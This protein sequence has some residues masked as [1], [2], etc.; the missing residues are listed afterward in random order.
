MK[1]LYFALLAVTLSACTSHL[2][3]AKTSFPDQDQ[4]CMA[5]AY[6]YK[7][8]YVIGSKADRVLTVAAGGQRKSVQYKEQDGQLIYM[9][10]ASRDT[11]VFGDAPQGRE[12]LCGQVLGISELKQFEGDTLSLTMHCQAKRDALSVAKGYL[13]AQEPPYR[14]DVSEE[15]LFSLTGKMPE[16]PR[17]P[18]CETH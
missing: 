3:I 16:A 10:E 4:T 14:F 6:W 5:Q 15:T 13:P 9:G 11:K 7:T 12:F 8:Q 18:T 17:P 1:K 2:Y